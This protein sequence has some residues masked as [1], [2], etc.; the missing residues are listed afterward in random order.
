[1]PRKRQEASKLNKQTIYVNHAYDGLLYAPLFLAQ[2]LGFFPSNVQVRLVEGDGQTMNKLVEQENNAQNSFSI[3]DPFV[4]EMSKLTA[5]TGGHDPIIIVGVLI[6]KLPLWLYSTDSKVQT[7]GDEKQLDAFDDR[8]KTIRCYQYPNTGWLIAKRLNDLYLRRSNL[9][10]VDFGKEFEGLTDDCL[11]VTADVLQ[12]HKQINAAKVFNYAGKQTELNP[13]LFTA[14]LTRKRIVD[15]NLG[16]VLSVLEALKRGVAELNRPSDEV[17]QL[18]VK[19]YRKSEE[20]IQSAVNIL[21]HEKIYPPTFEVDAAK[22][23]YDNARKE[24]K[25]RTE[26][27]FAEVTESSEPIPSLL[28]GRGWRYQTKLAGAFSKEWVGNPDTVEAV[29][30]GW[31]EKN[32][33]NDAIKAATRIWLK[34]PDA[35]KAMVEVW[36]ENPAAIASVLQPTWSG[37]PQ[38]AAL[39]AERCK[40]SSQTVKS[41]ATAWRG[42]PGA[43]NVVAEVWRQDIDAVASLVEPVILRAFWKV[44]RRGKP[45]DG[46]WILIGLIVEA[47]LLIGVGLIGHSRGAQ[48]PI[49][50]QLLCGLTVLL[51]FGVLIAGRVTEGKRMA[52]L[53][54]W[55]TGI[56]LHSFQLGAALAFATGH[57]LFEMKFTEL[58]GLELG[59]VAIIPLCRIPYEKNAQPSDDQAA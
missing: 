26:R 9:Q 59:A 36:Q 28:I 55:I 49:K 4:K 18:L 31:I 52:I 14:I 54:F 2:D 51:G 10:Q 34:D 29:A 56:A 6:Q 46:T 8:I 7:I 35:Q 41:V 58:L 39:V 16:I 21:I 13:Y 20:E 30:K 32:K 43:K 42:H 27:E 15:E 17:I 19:R 40:D 44:I 12:I 25:I 23:A 48:A 57:W 53:F 1:L 5:A 45:K 33:Q 38:A 22:V 11:V 24:W 3:C 47:I 50:E 37:C